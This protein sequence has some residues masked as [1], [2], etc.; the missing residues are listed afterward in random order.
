MAK[1]EE[2]HDSDVFSSLGI[3]NIDLASISGFGDAGYSD[4][5]AFLDGGSGGE[6]VS[7]DHQVFVDESYGFNHE[8]TEAENSVI[9]FAAGAIKRNGRQGTSQKQEKLYITH[10]DF[11][12]GPQ[13]DAFLLIYGHAEHLFEGKVEKIRKNAIS[14]FF[15]NR[16]NELSFEE[17]AACIDDVIRVDVLRLRIQY[18]FWIRDWHSGPLPED[19]VELP[20]RVQLMAAHHAGLLG[21]DLVKEAWF[22]PGL[23]AKDLI[24]L[25]LEGR[26]PEVKAQ[27]VDAFEALVENY[28]LSI[29]D[30]GKVYATGKNPMVQFENDSQDSMLMNRKRLSSIHWS[31]LF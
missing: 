13:R 25:V 30:S 6:S 20:N 24:K 28:V 17:A 7:V 18:E 31:R 21:L 11:E 19:A 2:N 22:E 3:G 23:D 1:K 8:L 5:G 15:C 26:G 12:E 27:Y 14:F 16:N 29:K 9:Q 10:E 4:F